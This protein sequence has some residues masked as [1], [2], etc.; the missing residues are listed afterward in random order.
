MSPCYTQ[1]QFVWL[2][3]HLFFM[4]L[5]FH[6]CPLRTALNPVSGRFHC[7]W[8]LFLLQCWVALTILCQVTSVKCICSPHLQKVHCLVGK[9]DEQKITV[10]CSMQ[11]VKELYREKEKDKRTQ[12]SRRAKGSFNSGYP[13]QIGFTC[14]D[15]ILIPW[16]TGLVQSLSDI[17][18][19]CTLFICIFFLHNNYMITFFLKPQK[20]HWIFK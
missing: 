6:V 15:V 13:R 7:C 17:S 11:R 9:T 14:H 16:I 10:K 8:L 20:S 2:P 1:S 4:K 3:V 18:F 12:V 19:I 5:H